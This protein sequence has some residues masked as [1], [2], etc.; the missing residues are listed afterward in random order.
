MPTV[1]NGKVYVASYQ[2]VAIFGL[3][4]DAKRA[5]L[6][7][8][9]F[10]STLIA[11][12]PGEHEIHGTVRSMNGN[13]I[14]IATRTGELVTIDS[15]QA[16]S[17]SRMAQPSVGHALVARGAMTGAGVFKADTIMHAKNNPAIWQPDR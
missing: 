6:P 14:T 5:Q 13:L 4:A 8:T 9:S 2:S 10:K 16:E 1:A 7:Q 15:T 17:K 11:L 3:G 12:A